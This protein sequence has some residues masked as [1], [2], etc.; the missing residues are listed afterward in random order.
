MIFLVVCLRKEKLYTVYGE[1]CIRNDALPV[2]TVVYIILT[3]IT[4]QQETDK[5]LQMYWQRISK[6]EEEG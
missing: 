1:N 4:I 3:L 6:S 2:Y 5:W